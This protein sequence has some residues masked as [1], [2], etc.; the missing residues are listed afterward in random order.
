[1]TQIMSKKFSVIDICRV[2]KLAR[3][4]F[5]YHA[6]KKFIDIDFEQAVIKAFKQSRNCYGTRKLK[7]VL[8]KQGFKASRKKISEVMSK[9]NLISKYTKK[10]YRQKCSSSLSEQLNLLGGNFNDKT[11]NEVLVSDVTYVRITDKFYYLCV[12]IDLY[13]RKIL[14]FSIGNQHNAD[15]VKRAFKSMTI[16]LHQVSIFHSDHGSEY[17]NK[18]IASILNSYEIIHSLSRRGN[19]YDNAV[20]ESTY[21]IIKTEFVKCYKFLSVELFEIEW[22]DYLNWYNNH[23]IHGSIGYI[24]PG[25]RYDIFLV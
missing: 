13:S 8:A 1:M 24:T 20:S 25:E 18:S 21:N 15:L 12:I 4:S 23:R 9:Y 16:D 2:L 14:G 3:S 17:V 6:K 10:Q 7:I 5:Y 19:P 11:K 22:F